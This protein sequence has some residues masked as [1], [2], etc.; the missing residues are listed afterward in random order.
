M[1][2]PRTLYPLDIDTIVE[3]V[4]KTGRL[5]VSHEAIRAWRL[6]RARSSRRSSTGRSTTSTRRRSGLRR[7][8]RPIPYNANLEALA[9]PQVEDIVR[10][11]REVL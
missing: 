7:R 1:I 10:A 5:V 2:D 11:V 3:S 6:R 8:T 4:K 9:I